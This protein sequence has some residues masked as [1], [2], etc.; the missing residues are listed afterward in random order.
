MQVDV[1]TVNG[2]VCIVKYFFCIIH[3]FS[4]TIAVE[5]TIKTRVSEMTVLFQIIDLAKKMPD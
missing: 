5:F 4:I 2:D 1:C 3:I